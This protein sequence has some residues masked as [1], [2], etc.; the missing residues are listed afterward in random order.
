LIVRTLGV[1]E[2]GTQF[3]GRGSP[4]EPKGGYQ[5]IGVGQLA[6]AWWAYREGHITKLELR[7]WFACWELEVRRR[8][9]GGKYKPAVEGLRQLVG[10]PADE[11]GRAMVRA[12]VNRLLAVGLLR[13][14]GEQGIT[15]AESPDELRVDDRSSLVE[16]FAELSSPNRKVPVPRRMI[17]RLAGGLSRSRMATVIAHLMRCLFYKKGEGC[18]SSGCCKASWIARVF[19]VTERSVYDARRYLVVEL[20]WLT[21]QE[22]TQ[23]VLNRDGLW[24]TIDLAWG[25]E[26]RT[27]VPVES[28]AIESPAVESPAIESTGQGEAPPEEPRIE[29]AGPPADFAAQFSGPMEDKNPLTGSKDQK[30]AGGGAPGFSISKPEEK[31]P[32]LLDITL[33]DLR[34]AKQL[35][36]LHAEAVE[37]ELVTSSEADRLKFFAGAVH[38]QS[39]G[40]NPTRLFAWMIW[41]GRWD[42]ITQ[43]DEDEAI[44]RLKKSQRVD[45]PQPTAELERG[46]PMLSQDARLVREV[47]AVLRRKG[48]HVDPFAAV[49]QHL[50]GWTRE[51][52]DAAVAEAD[53]Q[54]SATGLSDIFGKLNMSPMFANNV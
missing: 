41:K 14:C 40:A 15:F 30:P 38:A 16:M 46:G 32:T 3:K 6:M 50:P 21:T 43:A 52:W 31:K 48:I 36:Q 53:G 18:T 42:F 9:S 26:G 4:S 2:M 34:N 44:S 12:A 35:G 1:G 7:C 23:R 11:R 54:S 47:R 10:G 22:S 33:E 27:E 19:G 13:S 29:F 28:P 8:L 5:A 51:R 20:G 39:V 49:R 25:P 17:R 24:V 37:R 45:L